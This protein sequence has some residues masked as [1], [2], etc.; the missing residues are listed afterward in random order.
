MEGAQPIMFD[1]VGDRILFLEIVN[2]WMVEHRFNP[3][4]DL[5]TQ[6]AA[7]FTTSITWEPVDCQHIVRA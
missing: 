2:A 6:V 5:A 7:E 3:E 1:G 4:V